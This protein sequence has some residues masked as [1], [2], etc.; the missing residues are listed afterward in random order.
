LLIDLSDIFDIFPID[1]SIPAS[2]WIN[3]P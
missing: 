2:L 3:T 1:T